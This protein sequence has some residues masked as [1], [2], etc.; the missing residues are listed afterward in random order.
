MRYKMLCV[1]INIENVKIKHVIE[2]IEKM[3]R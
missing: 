2:G 1:N 3:Y